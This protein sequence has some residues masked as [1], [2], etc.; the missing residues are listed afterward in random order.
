M[1]P[2]HLRIDT[3]SFSFIVVYSLYFS[4]LLDASIAHSLVGLLL[5]LLLFGGGSV[6]SGSSSSSG[7]SSCCCSSIRLYLLLVW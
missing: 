2:F 3:P 5:L 1:L 4:Q 6:G 7:R